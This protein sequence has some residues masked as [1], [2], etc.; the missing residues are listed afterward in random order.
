MK[1]C[2]RGR[3]GVLKVRTDLQ[4]SGIPS[5]RRCDPS[6]KQL[7]IQVTIRSLHGKQISGHKA[8]CESLL[9]CLRVSRVDL[10]P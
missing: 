2:R 7:S 10:N 5:H 4:E 6:S 3:K 8:L 9:H 1:L